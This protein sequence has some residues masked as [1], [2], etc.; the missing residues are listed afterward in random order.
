MYTSAVLLV[1][2]SS[3]RPRAANACL[4]SASRSFLSSASD[5]MCNIIHVDI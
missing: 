5:V 4:A 3:M 2:T 1:A